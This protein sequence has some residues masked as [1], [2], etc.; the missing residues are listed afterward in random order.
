MLLKDIELDESTPFQYFRRFVKSKY[1]KP[2]LF[3]IILLSGSLFLLSSIKTY[4]IS[5]YVL[6]A[7]GVILNNVKIIPNYFSS[8]SS[9]PETLYIDMKSLNTQKLAYLRQLAITNG[10]P[11]IPDELKEEELNGKI[12]YKGETYKASFALTGQNMDH[13]SHP[14]KWS[15][16]VK[17]KGSG[18]ID[19]IKK[20]TLLIPHT[21]GSNLLSEFIGH[22]LMKYLGLIG[23]RYD[24]KKVIFNGKDYGIY[25]LEEHLDKRTLESNMLREGIIIKVTPNSFKVFKQTDMDS[26]EIFSKQIRYLEGIWQSFLTQE[27]ELKSLFDID[28]MAK[29]YALSDI[30]N[31]QHTHYLGNEFFHFNPMTNVL[32]PIGRE[33]DAP[34]ISEDDFLI[35]MK[36]ISVVESDVY[37]KNFQDLIFHDQDFIVSYLDSLDQL[38]NKDFLNKFLEDIKDQIASSKAILY[39][40]YPYLEANEA[41]LFE[42]IDN[43]RKTLDQDQSAMI[44]VKKTSGLNNNLIILVKN[45]SLIPAVVENIILDDFVYDTDI[46]VPPQSSKFIDL[47]LLWPDDLSS[48]IKIRMA[49][50]KKQTIKNIIDSIDT[51]VIDKD[52][53]SMTP[54]DIE[55]NN[56]KWIIDKNIIINKNQKLTVGPGTTIDMISGAGITS[57]GNV[58]FNGTEKKPIIIQSSD[59]TGVGLAVFSAK[60]RSSINHTIISGLASPEDSIRSLTSPFFF[61]ESDVDINNCMFENNRSEDAL[62]IFRSNFTIKNSR[63]IN[64]LS[65]AF[66]SDFSVGEIVKTS[67]KNI[68]NDAIDL[69]GSTVRISDI[70]IT[71]AS[72]KAISLGEESMSDG[73]KIIIENSNLG[74]SSKDLSFFSFNEVSISNSEV[75]VS[76]YQKK[77]EFGSSK[78]EISEASLF[79]NTV[80]FIIEKDSSIKFNTRIIDGDF[81]N[82]RELMYGNVYGTATSD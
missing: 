28:K 1:F 44:E 30:I 65:D 73:S 56:P 55:V 8:F 26:N 21:R 82:V 27:I 31:G 49:G 17:I 15:Y 54:K 43:I 60:E 80:D 48:S 20:F 2:S 41:I 70:R 7:R 39:S 16:R 45:M 81:E 10:N 6:Y 53:V 78:G 57:Y 40:T 9:N 59:G 67:F 5:N 62:N 4:K 18:R 32:E 50:Q 61:Y 36:N 38:A 58:I 22:K 75:A 14:Y 25:A 68:G 77:E 34:Y 35:F 63:F 3:L 69:S 76:L 29:Y 24:F 51:Q 13:I 33:W 12:T 47:G 71:G 23:L 72:D 19:G 66:D 79:D 64:I 52:L 11:T 37:S 46:V 42:Q 74:I